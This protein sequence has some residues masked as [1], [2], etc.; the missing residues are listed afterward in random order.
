MH[1]KSTLLITLL[2]SSTVTFAQSTC[3]TRVDAHQHASTPERVAYCLT[4][5]IYPANSAPV[6]ELIYAEISSRRP[7]KEVKQKEYTPSN[8][9]FHGDKYAITR[10]YVGTY[11][12]PEF[13]NATMSEQELAAMQQPWVQG[14]TYSTVVTQPYI[15]QPYVEQPY[16][17]QSYVEQPL[18]VSVISQSEYEV[19]VATK[20]VVTS[21]SYT[22]ETETGIAHR[23]SRPQRTM[24]QTVVSV[25]SAN[26]ATYPNSY[27]QSSSVTTYQPNPVDMDEMNMF[28]NNPYAQPDEF[29][30]IPYGR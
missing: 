20:P 5:E 19:P 6:P 21:R 26:N 27:S 8:S 24:E 9:Y 10:G 16:M 30:T 23:S 25:S 29:E 7:V 22:R 2:A 12:F 14:E 4:Q 11:Q 15:G 17:E 1:L 18:G 3:Q 28:P 13:H